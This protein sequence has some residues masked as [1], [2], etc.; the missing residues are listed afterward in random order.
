MA[1]KKVFAIIKGRVDQPTILTSEWYVP[2]CW[3]VSRRNTWLIP[4]YRETVT[5]L[6][7]NF[8]DN[9]YEGFPTVTKAEEWMRVNGVYDYVVDGAVPRANETDWRSS[10]DKEIADL[11]ETLATQLSY[12]LPLT[13]VLCIELLTPK[14]LPPISRKA[15]GQMTLHRPPKRRAE[16]QGLATPIDIEIKKPRLS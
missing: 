16:V 4:I 5:S 2:G 14:C 13:S 6:V 7:T 1:P 3:Q 10:V 15:R 9:K 12:A 11:Y 8:P